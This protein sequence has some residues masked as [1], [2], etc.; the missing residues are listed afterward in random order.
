MT[1]LAVPADAHTT[2]PIETA[3]SDT[4]C[5]ESVKR[6]SGELPRSFGGARAVGDSGSLE[7]SFKTRLLAVFLAA[8]VSRRKVR[9][10]DPLFVR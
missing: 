3:Q 2:G 5:V 7:G 10:M 9:W 4:D 6:V 1:V 8:L